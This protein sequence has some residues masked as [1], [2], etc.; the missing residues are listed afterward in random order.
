[1]N[2]EK[3]IIKIRK[4]FLIP[5]NFFVDYK[6]L[7]DPTFCLISDREMRE[8][9]SILLIATTNMWKDK[10]LIKEK[11]LVQ[12]IEN[13]GRK[14]YESWISKFQNPKLSHQIAF[15]IN[16]LVK[17]FVDE[18]TEINK[19]MRINPRIW[20]IIITAKLFEIPQKMLMTYM[21][22]MLK[23]YFPTVDKKMR[24]QF[25]ELTCTEDVKYIWSEVEK[26]QQ[27]Y[28]KKFGV[29]EKK[30]YINH[31]RDKLA[32]KLKES[33]PKISR[34]KIKNKLKKEGYKINFQTSYITKIIKNYKNYINK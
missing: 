6:I 16:Y 11:K 30:E 31:N 9:I 8:A 7:N 12:A 1:M 5:D 10:I 4:K 32:Y 3:E 17:F 18:S 20:G 24:I 14:R 13:F 34:E 23:H 29:I 2:V 25:N 22:S 28:T 21:N 33:D 15:V 19:P 27:E 26:Q